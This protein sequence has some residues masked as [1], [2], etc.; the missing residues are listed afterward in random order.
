M[1]NTK[2]TQEWG[3]PYLTYQELTNYWRTQYRKKSKQKVQ[4]D[5]HFIVMSIVALMAILLWFFQVGF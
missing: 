4:G 1:N 5:I 3:C 2:S